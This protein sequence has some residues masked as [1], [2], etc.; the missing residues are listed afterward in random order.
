MNDH[1][2]K[3]EPPVMITA[4]EFAAICGMKTATLRQKV[5]CGQVP[6]PIRIGGIVRWDKAEILAWL[7]AGAPVAAEWV[8][9]PK[10][11]ICNS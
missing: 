4:A 1:R 11:A 8:N 3:P 5:K 7:Q 10:A 2:P 9:R 6:A